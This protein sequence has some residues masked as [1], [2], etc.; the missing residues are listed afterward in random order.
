[1]DRGLSRNVWKSDFDRGKLM[2]CIMMHRTW[3]CIKLYIVQG[4][5][6]VSSST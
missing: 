5:G 6:I 4:Q 1:M 2:Q 3:K